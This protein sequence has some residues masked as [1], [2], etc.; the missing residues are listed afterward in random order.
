L[1]HIDD[2]NKMQ[3]DI[4]REIGTIGAG[5][6]ATALS[7]MINKEVVMNVPTV[8]ILEFNK[9]NE[10]L[11]DPEIPVVGIIFELSGDL[12]GNIMFVLKFKAARVLL[13]LLFNSD[14]KK[15]E[16]FSD[17]ERSA[18]MEVGNILSGSYLSAIAQ[19][20]KLK[21]IHSVPDIAIDMAGSILSVPA[22]Q[23]GKM[24]DS[25]LYIE[26][27]F[28]EGPKMVV[29]DFFLIPDMDSYDKLF[30]SLEVVD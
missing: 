13:S 26:T 1:T 6:A 3:I 7:K 8:N 14:I 29:G 2:L 25:T 9:V 12:H 15:E 22:I 20:T 24:G 30:K 27:E 16:R 11:G 4:L 28:Y 18:L 23:F 10:I 17:N 21:I 5:N 19:L